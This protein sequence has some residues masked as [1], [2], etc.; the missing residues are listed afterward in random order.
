[1]MSGV[2]TLRNM[3]RLKSGP[4]ETAEREQDRDDRRERRD[5]H[6][7]Y[8]AEEDDR[9]DAAGQN[10]EDVVGQPVAL[11]RV[12][13][14]ELHDRNAGQLRVEPAAGEIVGHDL[15]DIGDH[16]GEAVAGDDRRFER[17]HHQRQRAVL[18]QQL[19]AND[20]VG[21]NGLDEF[22]V[23]RA[24]RQFGGEQRRR[25]LAAL[26]RLARRK[27]R[28]QAAHAI[29]QL[30]VGDHVADLLEIGTRHQRLA[31]DHDQ[32]V[33][34]GRREAF[35]D[36]LVLL[37]VLGIGAEQLAQRIVDLDA[38]DAEDR[39]DHQGGQ[40][41]AGQDRRLDRDQPHALDP[42]GDALSRRRRLL[43][44][45]DV[46]LTFGVLFEHTLSSSHVGL[47]C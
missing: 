16:L 33:E 37:V 9:D 7:R 10:A 30:Q 45:L 32:H 18:G 38:L 31:F 23:G 19:A 29:D 27:Q 47:N 26:R 40:D 21:L 3:L 25:Q 34:F 43:D 22:V 24:F 6:E 8:L 14:L 12:A 41:D 5:D 11:D 28:D 4:A 20:L 46:D 13:D 39:R 35:G 17:Q 2:I 42:E 36:G 1:M 44:L 15:P